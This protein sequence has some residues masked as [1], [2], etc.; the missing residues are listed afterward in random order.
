LKP[1]QSISVGFYIR[2]QQLQG[3]AAAQSQ[4]TRTIDLPHAARAKQMVDLVL[5][6]PGAA[7]QGDFDVED[8]RGRIQH[9]RIEDAVS[10]FV[11]EQ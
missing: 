10:V 6:Q 9:G 11:R 8:L 4:V 5:P 1:R 3:D 2:P 7:G